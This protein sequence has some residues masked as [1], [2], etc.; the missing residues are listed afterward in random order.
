MTT[1]AAGPE[2]SVCA[3]TRT[4][5]TEENARTVVG[6][7]FLRTPQNTLAEVLCNSPGRHAYA[8]VPVINVK[9]ILHRHHAYSL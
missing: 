1:T 3:K 6:F 8:P 5:P 7:A 2:K 9:N 4:K